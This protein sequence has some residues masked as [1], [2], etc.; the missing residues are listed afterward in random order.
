M[1]DIL[2][3]TDIYGNSA[4]SLQWW[5]T[6]HSGAMPTETDSML[7]ALSQYNEVDKAIFVDLNNIPRAMRKGIASIRLRIAHV[8]AVKHQKFS[9]YKLH[10]EHIHT[11]ISA[12]CIGVQLQRLPAR[13]GARIFFTERG[14]GG[15]PFF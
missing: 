6:A 5:P 7:S 15:R 9:F 14:R 11:G 8:H 13:G 4:A 3:D 1:V 10:I 2:P 12:Q